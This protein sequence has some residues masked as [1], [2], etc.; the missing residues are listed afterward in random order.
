MRGGFDIWLWDD[1]TEVEQNVRTV[2]SAMRVGGSVFASDHSIADGAGLEDY[3]RIVDSVR[4]IGT[5]V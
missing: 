3:R 5:Y 1:P 2:L 4:E